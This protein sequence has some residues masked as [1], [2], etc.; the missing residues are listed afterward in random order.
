MTIE[1][2]TR[3]GKVPSILTGLK[4]KCPSCKTG[5]IFSGYLKLAEKCSNCAAPIGQIRA[6]DFPPYLTIFIVAHIII[7]ALVI[8]EIN[9]QP[10]MVP[11][12]IFWSATAIVMS[13]ALLPLLKGGV[14]G[15]MWSIGMKGDEQH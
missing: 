2:F 9:Y 12:M 5:K 10:P 1:T 6:D 15:F 3:N 7:P 14:V 8:V 13:L 11:Q 4:R